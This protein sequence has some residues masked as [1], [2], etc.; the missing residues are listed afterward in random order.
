VT[1]II[2]EHDLPFVSVIL[3]ANGK[4][5][6][7]ERVLV[8]TGSA[9]TVFRTDDLLKIDV[10]VQETDRI[11]FMA[12]IGGEEA[13]IEKQIENITVGSFSAANFTIQLAAMDYDFALDG[14]LGFDFLRHVGAILDLKALELR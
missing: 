10:Y 3:R 9:A 1:N 12:G 7:L 6:H 11:R 14:I 5:L 4:T 2:V 13:V 8:D